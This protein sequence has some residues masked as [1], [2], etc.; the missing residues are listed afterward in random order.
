MRVEDYKHTS[1]TRLSAD[2]VSQLGWLQGANL[3]L[4][5]VGSE[6]KKSY[7][8]FVSANLQNQ[9]IL[10]TTTFQPG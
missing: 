5:T 1:R 3:E 7:H 4:D 8:I 6:S 10:I 2:R 9:L